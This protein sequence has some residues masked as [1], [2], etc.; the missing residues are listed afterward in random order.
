[1]PRRVRGI[2]CVMDRTIC[3]PPAAMGTHRQL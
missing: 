3:G 2:F 1:M